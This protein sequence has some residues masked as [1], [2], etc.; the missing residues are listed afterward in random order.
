MTLVY[1]ASGYQ[2]ALS[3]FFG[4]K[5]RKCTLKYHQNKLLF[6][7]LKAFG[8]IIGKTVNKRQWKFIAFLL[9]VGISTSVVLGVWQLE[10]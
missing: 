2:S 6:L 10:I 9:F 3:M 5:Y 8:N 7:C 4:M 1:N